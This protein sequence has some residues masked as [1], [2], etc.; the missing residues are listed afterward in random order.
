[1]ADTADVED[2]ESR[3]VATLAKQRSQ[4]ETLGIVAALANVT[5]VP[6]LTMPAIFLAGAGVVGAQFCLNALAAETYPT[7]IRATGVGWALGIGR[8]GSVTGPL[9]GGVLLGWGWSPDKLVLAC[10][11]PA[12]ITAAAILGLA[13]LRARDPDYFPRTLPP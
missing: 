4:L 1:M 3:L 2:V 5:A 7:A 12:L 9:L 6:R 13:R 10:S 8:T 11:I